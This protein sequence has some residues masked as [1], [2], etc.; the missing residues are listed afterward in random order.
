MMEDYKLE[1][2]NLNR[3]DEYTLPVSMDKIYKHIMVE[4]LNL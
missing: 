4:N 1:W 2:M 3:R